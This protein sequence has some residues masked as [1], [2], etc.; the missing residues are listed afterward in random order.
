[1][2]HTIELTFGYEDKDGTVHREVTFGRRV[3]VGDLIV[4]DND[5]RA[6]NPVQYEDRTK[7]K[8]ITKFGTMK[9]P[10]KIDVLLGLNSIDRADVD[11]GFDTFCVESRGDR[12]A[13]YPT[14]K[15]TQVYFGFEIDGEIYDVVEFGKL[16][17]GRDEVDAAAM[18]LAGIARECFLL[19]RRITRLS[20]SE[21]P[22]A[23]I[24][25]PLQLEAFT[26]LDAQ[27][28]LLLRAGAAI[29]EAFFRIE[30]KGKGGKQPA[31]GGDGT[32]E[33]AADASN[34][35]AG[36]AGNEDKNLSP[37]SDET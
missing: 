14:E 3:T 32:V 33:R 22:I 20:K 6:R 34:G 35:S 19:G 29:A 31:E 23:S 4:L 24:D 15:S 27:D 17:T 1:M 9:L 26:N 12:E 2:E 28:L 13:A 18:S 16:I 7:L 37:N 11:T 25:G 8:A 10:L 30:G 21:D 5:P 36:D